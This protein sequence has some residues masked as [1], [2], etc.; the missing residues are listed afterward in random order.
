M[1]EEGMAP[2]AVGAEVEGPVLRFL[3][4]GAAAARGISEMEVVVINVVEAW[5]GK[6]R[7]VGERHRTV[8]VGS[9][10]TRKWE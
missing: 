8:D 10:M 2:E 3:V 1:P 5:N 6:G 9:A 4:A 7:K